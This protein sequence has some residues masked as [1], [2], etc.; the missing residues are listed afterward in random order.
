MLFR[1]AQ[2]SQTAMRAA[3]GRTG[4]MSMATNRQFAWSVTSAGSPE[5]GV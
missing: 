2:A 3:R 4:M 1:Y 5:P